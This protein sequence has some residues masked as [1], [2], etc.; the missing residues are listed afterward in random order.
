MSKRIFSLIAVVVLLC[1]SFASC[2]EGDNTQG[3]SN[4]TVPSITQNG[5][6]G[7]FGV[8]FGELVD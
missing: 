7:V 5:N 6:T 1:L 8:D 4:R 3:S 2:G